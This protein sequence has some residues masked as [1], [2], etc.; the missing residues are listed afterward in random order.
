MLSGVTINF[1]LA[2]LLGPQNFGMFGLVI[3]ILLTFE[4]FVYIGIPE[5]IKKY[6]GEQPGLIKKIVKA[7][8]PWQLCYCVGIFLILF[9]MAP[10][11]GQIF[12]DDRL[13]FLLRIASIDVIFYGLFNYFTSIQ[14]GLHN[15]FK[16]SV[17]NISYTLSKL[18]AIVGLVFAGFSLTG[19]LIGNVI[20]S[21]VGLMAGILIA[22]FPQNNNE[23][24]DIELKKY[25][26]FVVFNVLYFFG[27]SLILN[28]DLWAVKYYLSDTQVGYYVSAAALAKLPYFVSIGLSAV[29]LPSISHL[30][31]SKEN[32]RTS[33]VV[34]ESL[35]YVF[36]FLFLLNILVVSNSES[37]IE[38][39]FGKKYL[40]AAPILSI[41]MVG[42]SLVT[43]MAVI[44]TILISRNKMRFCSIQIILMVVADIILNAYLVPRYKLEGAAIATLTIGLMGTIINGWFV[45]KEIKKMLLFIIFRLAFVVSIIWV[46]SY[47]LNFISANVI[48]NFFI[49]AVTYFAL[50]FITR[51]IN[52]VD[53]TRL[54][55]VFQPSSKIV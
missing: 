7:T 17:L 34:S 14:N 12:E 25:F 52:T 35:R 20:G 42:L 30:I 22:R 45:Y 5:A 27:L 4:L 3:S 32:Q 13:S 37:I 54:K 21:V 31:A 50:L 23:K 43:L 41:L 39:L 19:A 47:Y 55:S 11:I 10:L 18:I 6:G 26:G 44:Q 51:I 38:L 53:V 15:F 24:Q 2:R 48:F 29:L 16:Y 49:L 40:Q 46:L 28:I 8:L 1:A 33:E 36:I 9:I